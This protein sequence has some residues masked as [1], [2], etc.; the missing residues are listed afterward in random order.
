MARGTMP[1]YAWRPEGS[2]LLCVALREPGAATLSC[3]KGDVV[4][5][6]AMRNTM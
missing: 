5:R 1:I 6:S 4:E 2:G 3:D